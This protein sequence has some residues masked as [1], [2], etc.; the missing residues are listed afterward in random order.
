MQNDQLSYVSGAADQPLLEISIGAALR[1]AAQRHA[2]REA[3]VS[4]FQ[5]QRFTYVDLDR[6]ADRVACALLSLGVKAGDRVAIWSANRA[7]WLI[8]HHGAVRI[9]AIVVTVNPALRKDEALYVFRDSGAKIV[10]ASREF[11]GFSF[12]GVLGEIRAELPELEE[13]IYFDKNPDDM[14][15]DDFL[16]LGQDQREALQSIEPTISSDLAC[17][18]QYTSGTTGRPKGAL[19]THRNI[20]NNG[21][22]VG[23]RQ[24][25]SPADRICLPVPFFHCFGIVL[26]A[27]AAVT[28]GSALVLPSESFDPKIVMDAIQQEK[29]TS[30]YGVPMMYISLLSH[31][32]VKTADFSSLRTGCMG[33]SPCPIETMRQAVDVLHMPDI[34]VVYGMTET[35]PISFQ[36]L[37]DDDNDVRV[38]TVGRVHPHIEAKVADPA[39]H[40]AVAH[41][42]P[43]EL[44]IRGYSVMRGYWRNPEGTREAIDSEGWMHSG[45]L[46]VMLPDGCVQIV[47]RIKNTI[48]RGGENIYPREV[49]EFLLTL[50]QVS[51]AYIFGIPDAKY[52]EETCAWIRLKS[53]VSSSPEQIRELCKG[54]IATFKIPRY[55]RFV[56][57][58]PTTASGKVQYFRMREAELALVA[59]ESKTLAS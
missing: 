47:G 40:S 37:P 13:I 30:F 57:S 54:K 33:G 22:F 18:L 5:A 3:L 21:Y 11:R 15:W 24:R 44:C 56:D 42:T 39:T 14:F 55:V 35:S 28:H 1:E 46:A 7:E 9:G 31:P 59:N 41:N 6:E 10:F 17:S 19:L 20:L 34:T 51:E 12:A 29:C 36:T 32:D 53:D 27:L 25:L 4:M 16:N 23:Q 26:G 45:D 2:S 50:P 48:I 58:F 52:G 49:E 8:A 43:G 38:T